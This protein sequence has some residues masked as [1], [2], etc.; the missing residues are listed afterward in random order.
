MIKTGSGSSKRRLLQDLKILKATDKLTHDGNG[1]Q[2]L[3]PMENSANYPNGTPVQRF[4]W[5]CFNH[6]RRSD[7]LFEGAALFHALIENNDRDARTLMGY[8]LVF[9]LW[10]FLGW[11]GEQT[12]LIDGAIFALR[13]IELHVEPI[14]DPDPNVT[15]RPSDIFH[16]RR[17]RE[18]YTRAIGEP[19]EVQRKIVQQRIERLATLQLEANYGFED[20]LL[21][22]CPSIQ[23]WTADLD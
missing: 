22:V 2:L 5:K 11:P 14:I 21:G 23:P 9:A 20:G 8:D 1:K 6:D 18:Y 12:R 17:S 7:D 13:M 15:T 3:I 16:F 4:I 10:R 19:V